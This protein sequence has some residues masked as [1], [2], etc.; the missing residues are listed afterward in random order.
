MATTLAPF[1]EF[2]P[3]VEA[4]LT[5]VFESQTE[6]DAASF[7]AVSYINQNFPN[8]RSL[9]RVDQFLSMTTQKLETLDQEIYK[10]VLEQATSGKQADDDVA[11]VKSAIRDLFQKIKDIKEKAEE[12]EVMVQ[13]ISRDI[14]KLD[15]AKRHLTTTIT[16]LKRLHMLVTAVDQ[17]E[18]MA[19]RR[20]YGEAANL[21]NA[22]NQL[23]S[24][25]EQYTGVPK[26]DELRKAV[27]DTRRALK[28]QVLQDFRDIQVPTDNDDSGGSDYDRE[29][30]RDACLVVDALGHEVR[31]RI[32]ERFCCDQL[33][34]YDGIFRPGGGEDTLD[35]VERR[36][37][38]WRRMLR[39]YEKTFDAVFP[40]QWEVD[41]ELC[42]DFS[43]R[44]RRHIEKILQAIDPPESAD[45]GVLLKALDTTLKFE[46][47][48]DKLFNPIDEEAEES[49]GIDDISSSDLSRTESAE[50]SDEEDEVDE[51]D[52]LYDDNGNEVDPDSATGIRLKYKRRQEMERR[53]LDQKNGKKQQQ[54]TNVQLRRKSRSGANGGGDEEEESPQPKVYF[55]G[56][57]S[58]C[59]GNY[60][61]A[62]VK[63]ER[64]NMDAKLDG[65]RIDDE[66]DEDMKTFST[67][68]NLFGYMHKS[69]KRCCNLNTG[70]AFY[71]LHLE[72]KTVLREYA[73][74]LTSKLAKPSGTNSAGESVYKF[75]DGDDIP[76]LACY[77]VNT[78]DY[79]LESMPK[80]EENIQNR[81][82]DEFQEKVDLE[83]EQDAMYEVINM[84]IKV[85]AS[86]LQS[87]VGPKLEVRVYF[88]FEH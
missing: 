37:A 69:I 80:L 46:R 57:I 41:K 33:S 21:L 83:E 20:E 23:S 56:L 77:I 63:K 29:Q 42:V 16:G 49:N 11:A 30:L 34:E 44:T 12:S 36:Y 6:L 70:Q 25:F 73:T 22:V 43:R 26:V 18:F 52:A 13:E 54:E 68:Y 40:S 48:S 24:H 81:I 14:K 15:Y 61:A 9:Q 86:G 65:L 66:V 10:S 32:T 78:A 3:H 85:L 38:L 35:A 58:S 82:D 60:M 87:R 62:Y 1:T 74:I 75:G 67:S 4:T 31:S 45:V 27:S 28:T 53:K 88:L 19:Q 50:W 59:F 17:L 8:E 79:C 7:D 39:R 76:R 51:A 84:A 71:D 55:R 2:S 5:T 72:Y 47:E 64:D